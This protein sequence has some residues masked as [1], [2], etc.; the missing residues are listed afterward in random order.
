MYVLNGNYIIILVSKLKSF[1]FLNY[2]QFNKALQLTQEVLSDCIV[3]SS[4]NKSSCAILGCAKRLQSKLKLL[5]LHRDDEDA[6]VELNNKGDTP[7]DLA[8]EAMRM[9]TAVIHCIIQPDAQT[10]SNSD[11]GNSSL[12]LKKFLN[13]ILKNSKWKI[14]KVKKKFLKMIYT[15]LLLFHVNLHLWPVFHVY[16]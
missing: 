6:S 5:P 13:F 16:Q 3:T 14:S 2:F 11:F 4:K 8:F 10:V 1:I 12:F 7:L 15:W 9:Y